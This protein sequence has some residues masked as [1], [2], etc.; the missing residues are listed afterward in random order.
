MFNLLF[1]S[2]SPKAE[3]I[4]GELQPVLK[5]IVDVVTDYDHGLKAVFEKRPEIVCI[6]GHIGGVT[7]ESVARHIQMLLGNGAPKFILLHTGNCKARTIRGLYEHLIDLSQPN[8]MLAENV[9]C[10]LKSLLGD[11]WEKIY[12]PPKP[13]L[14]SEW[15]SVAVPEVPYED[16]DMLVD[17]FLSDHEVSVFPVVKKDTM[18]T[19]MP[20]ASNATPPAAEFKISQKTPPSIEPSSEDLLLAFEENYHPKSLFLRRTAVI[21]LVCV[22]CAAG[23]GYLFMQKS[24]TIDSLKHRFMSRSEAKLVPVTVL[25]VA[26][27][28][29]TVPSSDP[30]PTMVSQLPAFIPKDGHDSSYSLKNPG[31]ERY[32]NKRNEFRVFSVSGRIKAVQVKAVN[33]APV[34]KTLMKSVLQ[35]IAGTSEYHITS[36]N[37]K[38]GVHV[39]NCRIQ[40]N[41]EM[42]IYRKNGMMKAF[43]VSVD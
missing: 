9:I 18:T 1:I 35:E 13:S 7:G 31:W 33:D 12:I 32:V 29:K 36:R 19:S 2:D 41:A 30:Q 16:S 4:K 5:I 25:P 14:A 24:Q 17:G 3:Y 10:T 27:V 11:Q 6:Q 8:E 38:A 15:S 34:L 39:E 43:V 23:G 28:K 21:V 26:P 37:S 20:I 22:V 42:K 40:N